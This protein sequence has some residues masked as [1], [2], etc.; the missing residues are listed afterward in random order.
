M[1][2]MKF[3]DLRANQ[4]AQ[5]GLCDRSRIHVPDLGGA[6]VW[7]GRNSFHKKCENFDNIAVY[8]ITSLKS[9]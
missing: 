7:P 1:M 2:L 9:K 8:L 6:G 4:I 3:P 5:I